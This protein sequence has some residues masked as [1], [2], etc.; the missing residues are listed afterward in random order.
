MLKFLSKLGNFVHS[1]NNQG[2]YPLHIAVAANDAKAVELLLTT[3]SGNADFNMRANSPVHLAI[4][5]NNKQIVA[6]LIERVEKN[7]QYDLHNTLLHN[8]SSI[9]IAQLLINQGWRLDLA[10]S[11]GVTPFEILLQ[12]KVVTPILSADPSSVPWTRSTPAKQNILHILIDLNLW[13]S[14][15]H[16]EHVAII[17]NNKDSSDK[18]PLLKAVENQN[19]EQVQSV[20]T[21]S[22]NMIVLCNQFTVTEHAIKSQAKAEIIG[23]L[24]KST[25]PSTEPMLVAH[26]VK[27]S[28]VGAA[29]VLLNQGWNPDACNS[30]K[31]TALTEAIMAKKTEFYSLLLSSKADCSVGIPSALEVTLQDKN[32]A[33]AETLICNAPSDGWK[34]TTVNGE[35]VLHISIV[36]NKKQLFDSAVKGGTKVD[37]LDSKGRTAL[38][39]AATQKEHHYLKVLLEM[40]ANKH[41]KDE[42]GKIPLTYA[43]IEGNDD[44]V[45]FLCDDTNINT[46]DKFN[47]TPLYYACFYG[48][49]QMVN[50]LLQRGADPSLAGKNDWYPL[51]A[52]VSGNHCDIVKKLLEVKA[53]PN[54]KALSDKGNMPIHLAVKK[55]SL[56]MVKMLHEHG[57]DLVTSSSQWHPLHLAV[58]YEDMGIVKYLLQ[59]KVDVN[60]TDKSWQKALEWHPFDTNYYFQICVSF[61]KA[62]ELL[63][64]FNY[65]L[66]RNDVSKYL[67]CC[68][69]TC[70][71][72][73]F[74]TMHTA[75]PNMYVHEKFV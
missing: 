17:V 35:T 4:Q 49:M 25:N 20:L 40:G 6:M 67:K 62:V 13:I 2:K 66:E 29:S 72:N 30:K 55:Q 48:R 7:K 22:P 12:K 54:C 19:Y 65:K 47:C 57:A 23:C 56:A 21:L 3:F 24:A 36:A 50:I 45:E 41:A 10:N 32:Y 44:Y 1:K 53:N 39:C 61:M 51:H 15:E 68:A 5:G 28:N 27:H 16:E 34:T 9:D 38:H 14:P 52:A 58:H 31:P 46:K 63:I 73:A 18:T 33:L 42:E 59:S 8:C 64:Q 70:N 60:V 69:Y 37:V 71:E 75:H 11:N 43:S 26:A 74:T